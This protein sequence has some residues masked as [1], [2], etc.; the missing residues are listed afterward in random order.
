MTLF[1]ML[2]SKSLRS[3]RFLFQIFFSHCHESTCRSLVCKTTGKHCQPIRDP[4]KVT[5]HT[6]HASRRVISFWNFL[7]WTRCLAY[8]HGGACARAREVCGADDKFGCRACVNVM[9]AG[10]ERWV[11]GACILSMLR[12]GSPVSRYLYI[13]LWSWLWFS[14]FSFVKIVLVFISVAYV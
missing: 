3:M 6:Q 13:D 2:Q 8:S 7:A 4:F 12:D 9:H 10:Q 14:Y 11:W 5:S 1:I